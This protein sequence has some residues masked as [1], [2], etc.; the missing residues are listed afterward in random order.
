M[1]AKGQGAEEDADGH[2]RW[3]AISFNLVAYLQ[4]QNA[5]PPKAK[6]FEVEKKGKRMLDMGAESSCHVVDE[7]S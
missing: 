7:C 4:Q 2:A 1:K 6:N 3:L 5:M